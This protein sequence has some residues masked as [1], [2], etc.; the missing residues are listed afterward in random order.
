M[1]SQRLFKPFLFTIVAAGAAVLIFSGARLSPQYLDWRFLMLL[2]AMATVASRLSIPIPH[3]KGEVTVGDTLIFLTL[4]LYGGEAAVF[5][6]AVDGVS[7]SL[8]VTRKPR[9]WLFNACQMAISTFV[10]V[11]TLRLC[12]GPTS[13]LNHNGYSNRAVAAV[14]VMALAQYISNSGLV[15]T[16]TALKTNEPLYRTWRNSYLWTSMSYFAGASVASVAV[17][18]ANDLSGYAVMMITPIVAIIYF[19]YK[20]YLRN[21]QTSMEKAEQAKQHVEELSQYIEEQERIREQF[22]Q[23]EKMSA[24]GELASGVA[25]DFNNTLAGILGRAELMLRKVEDPD[26][27]HGLEIIVKS[28]QDGAGTVKRIQDFARQRRDHDFEPVAVDQLLIDVNEITR[29]RWKDRAQAN[30][31]HINLNLQI[32]TNSLIMGDPSELREVLV[33]LVFNAVDAMPQGGRLTL[34][35]RE[36]DGAVEIAVSDTG[37]GMTP[38]IRS[39]VFDPFFT[40]KGKAGMGLGLAVCYGIVQRHEG[41]VEIE[42]ELGQGTTFRIRLP[43]THVKPKPETKKEPVP[44]LTLV[45]KSGAQG[46]LVVDDEDA[47]R[48]LLVDILENQGYE[49]TPAENGEEALKFFDAKRFKAV[50]TDVGMPGMSG[51]ELA[52]A[53]RERDAEMPVAVIT[54]W[55][56]AVS[57]T[58]QETAKVDWVVTKP[59]SIDRI[60]EITTELANRNNQGVAALPIAAIGT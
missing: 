12:F 38:E 41:T 20:T 5:M 59:F 2:V 22:G 43:I 4:L 32:D 53:I 28:A 9:V 56:D 21:V 10:T 40:T 37:T 15:A 54:G 6:A 16:Y 3:V 11:W 19:T 24:L 58:E 39:R 14:C 30:N 52:R 48:R 7:S 44:R 51:W 17:R 47:V 34:A 25:H 57:S 26:I 23:I 46:I 29:P 8:Y 13:T 60:T 42:S 35:A 18:L 45:P 27:R 33:N 36:A 49:V 55:G 50:F 31:I 1:K